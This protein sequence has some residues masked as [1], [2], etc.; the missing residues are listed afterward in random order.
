MPTPVQSPSG[1]GPRR[2]DSP[3]SHAIGAEYIARPKAGEIA[4]FLRDPSLLPRKPPTRTGR[5]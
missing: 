1:R 4:P 3:R 2:T 5:P